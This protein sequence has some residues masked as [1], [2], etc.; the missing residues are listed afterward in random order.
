MTKPD[1]PSELR[2]RIVEAYKKAASPYNPEPPLWNERHFIAG[3]EA[4][5]ALL[6]E[7]NERLRERDE[8]RAEVKQ[9]RDKVES[10]YIQN[11]R[12]AQSLIDK[13]KEIDRLGKEVEELMKVD[14]WQ[15]R[16]NI[17]KKDL[18]ILLNTSKHNEHPPGCCVICDMIRKYSPT[19]KVVKP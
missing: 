9:L 2:E 16:H 19:G 8:A 18:E 12:L 1:M 11:C 4:A 7:E 5:Y 15:D 10:Q 6:R 14:Y 3:A 13:D 17:V